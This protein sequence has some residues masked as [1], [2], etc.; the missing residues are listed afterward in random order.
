M[1]QQKLSKLEEKRQAYLDEIEQ[2]NASIRDEEQ[3]VIKERAELI[4]NTIAHML[5]KD[6]LTID[7][8]E[9][10]I[11]DQVK[12]KSDRKLLGFPSIEKAS[13]NLATEVEVETILPTTQSA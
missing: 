10:L 7:Q 3:R 2:I 4:G 6:K 9:A 13:I 5:N 11:G 8:L 12:R 1:S